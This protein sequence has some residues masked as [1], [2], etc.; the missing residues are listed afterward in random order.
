MKEVFDTFWDKISE[1]KQELFI[2]STE[3]NAGNAL[4]VYIDDET[5]LID[6]LV[7]EW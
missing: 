4:N 6:A 5:P 3:S 2:H 1:K 7:Y